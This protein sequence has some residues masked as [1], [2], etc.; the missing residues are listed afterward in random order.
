MSFGDGASLNVTPYDPSVSRMPTAAQGNA[1]TYHLQN[2]DRVFAAVLE[3][4]LPYY[5]RMRPK[6]IEYL[7]DDA[8]RLMPEL[9]PPDALA[10][11]IDL[12]Q[13]HVHPWERSGIG[14]VGLQFGCTWDVEHGLGVMMHNDCVV[15][16]GGADVSFAWAPK[17]AD[18]T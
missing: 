13:V 16:L 4:L 2:G 17:E 14:Y 5:H 3:T 15:D 8:D 7:G 11:L 12:R 18:N 10:P 1:L 9:T 6:Y